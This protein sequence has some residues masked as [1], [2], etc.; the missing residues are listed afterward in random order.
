MLIPPF[1][2]MLEHLAAPDLVP[3]IAEPI[4]R[5][6]KKEFTCQY[7]PKQSIGERYAR[8][9]ESGTPFCFTIDGQTKEDG[10]VTVRD[11]N[12][13]SQIRIDKSRCAEYL[14]E[15]LRL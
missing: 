15:Q 9:D 13:A 5:E 1:L 2:R 11:R 7:D 6:I 3:E 10:T 14:H 4:Y 8:M 12:D